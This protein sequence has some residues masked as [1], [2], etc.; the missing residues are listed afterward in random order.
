MCAALDGRRHE[1]R[2]SSTLEGE[3]GAMRSVEDR[4]GGGVGECREMN[5][6]DDADDDGEGAAVACSPEERGFAENVPA[7][8]A[9]M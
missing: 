9:V 4:V 1:E 2:G 8:C 5:D 3:L 6:D 7:R